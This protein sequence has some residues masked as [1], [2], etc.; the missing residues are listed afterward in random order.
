MWTL[1]SRASEAR[2]GTTAEALP[3]YDFLRFGNLAA[4]VISQASPPRNLTLPWLF[5][6]VN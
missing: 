3:T 2:P 5:S 6:S 1:S 4:Y